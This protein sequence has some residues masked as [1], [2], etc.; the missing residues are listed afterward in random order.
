MTVSPSHVMSSNMQPTEYLVHIV[1]IA[2][3]HTSP[4]HRRAGFA[5][6]VLQAVC[7]ATVEAIERCPLNP[8]EANDPVWMHGD[9]EADNVKAQRWFQAQGFQPTV[10]NTWILFRLRA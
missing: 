2:A 10:K 9:C 1:S 7:N 4:S 3:L 5:S 6:V 8:Y